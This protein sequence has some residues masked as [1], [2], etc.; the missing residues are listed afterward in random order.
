M[1]GDLRHL[2]RTGRDGPRPDHPRGGPLT[3]AEALAI[4]DAVRTGDIPHLVALHLNLPNSARPWTATPPARH[5]AAA[6][7]GHPRHAAG[8]ARAVPD[9]VSPLGERL[10]ALGEVERAEFLA[11]LVRSEAAGVLGYAATDPVEDHRSFKDLGFD[12][13]TA[14]ELRNR[15]GAVTG[16]RLPATLVFD[17]PSPQALTAHL[18]PLLTGEDRAAPAPAGR[19]PRRAAGND[20]PIAIVA[21]SCRYPGG[22]NSPEDLWRLVAEGSDAIGPFPDNRGWDIGNLYDPAP[23]A[24]GKSYVLEGGFVRDADRFDPV[25]FGISPREALAMD[26]QQRLLLEA[27]WEVFERAGIDPTSQRGSRTGV[28]AGLMYHDYGSTMTVLPEGVEGYLGTGTSGSVLAG[29]VS[30][31]FGLE[32]PAMTVDTACSSSLVT[33]H[34]ACQALRAGECDMALA[35]GVTVLST[36]AVFIDFSTQG[37]L[38]S[39]GRCKTFSADADGT[40]WGEGVGVLLVERL[41]DARRHGHEVLAVIRGSAVNQDG[42]SNGLTAP[43]GPSQERVIRQALENARLSPVDVD[44]VEAH[45]TGTTLG[46]PIEAQA[47]LAAY[48]QDRQEPLYLGSLKSNIGHTQAAAGGRWCD[49]DGA[50]DAPRRAAGHPARGRADTACRLGGGSVELLTEKRRWPE[51]DR[52]RRAGVSSFGVSGT[53]AHVILEEYRPAEPAADE[54]PAAPAGTEVLSAPAPWLLSGKSAGALQTAAARLAGLTDERDPADVAWG[55][56]TGRAVL[57]HRAVVVGEDR[58]GALRA[59]AR[60]VPHPGVVR[61]VA[62]SGGAPV[63]VFP[64]QGSQWLGMGRELAASSPVFRQSLEECAAALEPYVDWSLEGVLDSDDQTLWNRVD[65]VQPVLWALMVCLARLWRACGV[66]PSA[67]VGHSQGEIAAAVVVGGLT[68]TDGARVVAL[69]SRALRALAGHGGMVS[70]AT[71]ATVAGELV[72]GLG[73]RVSVAAVNGPTPRWSPA[74]PTHWTN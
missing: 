23:D 25:P 73:G 34:L 37:A 14:V 47:L 36:P 48:G 32:G 18:L 59:L 66:T 24:S 63:W 20:E 38:S 51:T 16:L 11:E 19:A 69:R 71:G 43:N 52:P 15:L 58:A 49:Q 42:A 74:S 7:P 30:Y 10:T 60:D 27:S 35:G 26:P 4:L 33:L 41:S 53:N 64:G 28:F 68:L 40:G 12:S 46:D 8:A 13:L 22:V 70:L 57:E 65:V 21:M 56:L 67:V 31:T 61:G 3:T 29:R 45:G 9:A 44:V 54:T 72:T 55:L 39:N 6:R 2:R 1:G 17:H 62:R 50:G 5:P